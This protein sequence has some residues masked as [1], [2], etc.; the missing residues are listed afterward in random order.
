MP[1]TS[2]IQ[3][4]FHTQGVCVIAN[5]DD[6]ILGKN[7]PVKGILQRDNLGRRSAYNQK[8]PLYKILQGMR[9]TH[10][11]T[12]LPRTTFSWISSKVK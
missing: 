11:W 5:L 6:L 10:K 4:G 2:T 8:N 12:S 1:D 9:V 7:S 3:V